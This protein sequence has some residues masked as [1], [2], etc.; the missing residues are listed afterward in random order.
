M[1]EDSAESVSGYLVASGAGQTLSFPIVFDTEGREIIV[2]EACRMAMYQ[3]ENPYYLIETQSA[4]SSFEELTQ[5]NCEELVSEDGSFEISGTKSFVYEGRSASIDVTM[6]LAPTQKPLDSAV[7]WQT[8]EETDALTATVQMIL[9]EADYIELLSEI[10]SDISEVF[11]LKKQAMEMAEEYLG[12]GNTEMTLILK[13]TDPLLKSVMESGGE[14]G[15]TVKFLNQAIGYASEITGG[16][17]DTLDVMSIWA[18]PAIHTDQKLVYALMGLAELA[19]SSVSDPAGRWFTS[20]WSTGFTLFNNIYR[21]SM[22]VGP[23]SHMSSQE[24]GMYINSLALGYQCTNAGKVNSGTSLERGMKG[25]FAY[26]ETYRRLGTGEINTDN[27]LQYFGGGRKRGAALQK[28]GDAGE[29]PP[30]GAENAS[31]VWITGRMASKDNSYVN[32]AATKFAIYVNDQYIGD[33]RNGGLTEMFCVGLLTDAFQVGSNT[34]I[35]DYDTNPGTHYVT[36]ETEFSIL[37]D[38]CSDVAYIG[39]L[40]DYAELRPLPD[41]AVYSENIY[42]DSSPTGQNIT[43]IAGEECILRANIYNRGQRGGWADIVFSCGGVELY[44]IENQYIGAFSCEKVMF[45]WSPVGSET[46]IDVAIVNKTVDVTERRD[47][48]N[49]ASVNVTVRGQA[50]PVIRELGPETIL[51][52]EEG[53]SVYLSADVANY[54]D[55]TAAAFTVDGVDVSG[56]LSAAR[57]DNTMRYSILLP[58]AELNLDAHSLCFTVTYRAGEELRTVSKTLELTV[59]YH[60]CAVDGHRLRHHEEVPSDFD[61][62][63]MEEYWYCD[64]CSQLFSDSE[65]RM[66][67]T[68]ADILKEALFEAVCHEHVENRV[69]VRLRISDELP[70]CWILLAVY[71]ESGKMTEIYICT[72]AERLQAMT[73]EG[74]ILSLVDPD[75]IKI[76]LL[77]EQYRPIFP[78]TRVDCGH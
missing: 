48:N 47:E 66:E 42:T 18:N 74:L 54:L 45:P 41:F 19:A 29:T 64:G 57:Y 1:L 49:S 20:G 33:V 6:R 72:E 30:D 61:K 40:G 38:P 43:A 13:I 53:N 3:D 4:G 69:K 78:W 55:V 24:L 62:P 12:I 51:L 37:V 32:Q 35:R 8:T 56:T 44:R 16:I 5:E 59:R 14:L 23:L 60:D 10:F 73:E 15:E 9:G 2:M 27:I 70:D 36:A 25:Y 11:D 58:A 22:G 21:T 67:I 52:L 77:D 68:V 46:R 50:I 39:E 76:F 65:G 34:I 63:G 28:D 31:L 17:S 71:D 26:A 7:S 75:F